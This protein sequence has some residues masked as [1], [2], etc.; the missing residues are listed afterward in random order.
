MQDTSAKAVL[1]MFLMSRAGVNEAHM[2]NGE[3]FC[4]V[5]PPTALATS[6]DG[7]APMQQS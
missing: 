3:F 5:V 2:H 1:G 6:C 7:T 4:A